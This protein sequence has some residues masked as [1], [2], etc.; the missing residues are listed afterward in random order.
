MESSNSLKKELLS[1]M[2]QHLFYPRHYLGQ[3]FLVDKKVFDC[4]IRQLSLGKEDAVVEIGMGPGLISR[5][6]AQRAGMYLG[7]EID[8]RFKDFH[9][10]LFSNLD[11]NAH[12]IYEDALKIDFSLY[13]ERLAHYDRLLIFSNLPYYI[14][15]EL[16]L[17]MIRSFP[18]AE[19]MLFMV[20]KAALNRVLARP[21]TKAYGPLSIVSSLWGEWEKVMTVSG[22]SFEPAPRTTSSLYSLM[23][24]PDSQFKKTASIPAFQEFAAAVLRNRRKTL[25]NS[26]LYTEIQE[27]HVI[28]KVL[29]SFLKSEKLKVGIRAESLTTQQFAKLYWMLVKV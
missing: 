27:D 25:A 1:L 21:G 20:E 15:T 6:L 7:C 10:E 22:H 8:H 13:R 5:E 28:K 19:Q 12:F 9:A 23:A 29:S 18:Q 17:K 24:R 2:R 26:L 3:N 11:V 4:I 16:I 14:T